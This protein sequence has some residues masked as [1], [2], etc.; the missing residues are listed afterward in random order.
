MAVEYYTK[1]L[2]LDPESKV[3]YSNRS[4]ALLKLGKK[5]EARKD[6]EKSIALDPDWPKGYLRKASALIAEGNSTAAAKC[7]E[8]CLNRECVRK[9]NRQ[10]KS[11]GRHATSGGCIEISSSV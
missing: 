4:L 11:I 1:A 3:F 8:T 9:D 7:Y 2:K 5:E 10:K 6:A